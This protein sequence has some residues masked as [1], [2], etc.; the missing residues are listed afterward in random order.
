MLFSEVWEIG[1]LCAAKSTQSSL[2]IISSLAKEY[3]L[4]NRDYLSSL[5]T[6]FVSSLFDFCG[7]LSTESWFACIQFMQSRSLGNKSS[8][9]W[10]R[11]SPSTTPVSL[12]FWLGLIAHL[13]GFL[14]MDIVCARSISTFLICHAAYRF[15]HYFF[16]L[17]FC[18]F[19]F[20]PSILFLTW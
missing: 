19:S 9:S 6:Y 17:T 13:S 12:S 11:Y 20:L 1:F 2:N 7:I 14:S 10:S 16:F 5:S 18:D 4:S 15:V 3:S 8:L